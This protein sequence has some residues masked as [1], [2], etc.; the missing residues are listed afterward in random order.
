[1][2]Y[3]PPGVTS[4]ISVLFPIWRV[5]GQRSVHM[6]RISA[7]A[8]WSQEAQGSTQNGDDRRQLG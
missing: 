3:P 5:P 6:M 1:M 7:G 4:D 8:G 2:G